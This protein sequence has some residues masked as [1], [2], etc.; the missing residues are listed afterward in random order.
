VS[1][2]D[3]A[4]GQR[5]EHRLIAHGGLV[6]HGERIER[7][8]GSTPDPDVRYVPGRRLAALLVLLAAASLIARAL[9]H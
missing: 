4:E 2:R 6:P 9:G 7:V 8:P 3:E 1:T 5:T